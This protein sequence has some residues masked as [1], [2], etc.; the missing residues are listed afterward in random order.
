MSSSGSA[1]PLAR[2]ADAKFSSRAAEIFD[3]G[4]DAAKVRCG[5]WTG[6]AIDGRGRPWARASP[7][8]SDGGKVRN[9][10][11]PSANP[12]PHN[13]A[14]RA[15]PTS[16]TAIQHQILS[17]SKVRLI[18]LPLR[19]A[20]LLRR[21]ALSSGRASTDPRGSSHRRT[22]IVTPDRPAL[23]WRSGGRQSD[24]RL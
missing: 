2:G 4:C 16:G 22:V 3:Q 8:W 9:R 23:A 14:R 7:C 11:E 21:G 12:K 5:A 1:Q 13:S 15:E 24:P 17:N 6:I 10:C 20:E 19:S 18:A